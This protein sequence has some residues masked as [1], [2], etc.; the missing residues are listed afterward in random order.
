MIDGSEKQ[1]DRMWEAIPACELHGPS[2]SSLSILSQIST[3]CLYSC[4]KGYKKNSHTN[5]DHSKAKPRSTPV[6]LIPD[7]QAKYDA[8]VELHSR[9]A[10]QFTVVR[11]GGL[12]DEPA[13]GAKAG[14]TQVGKTRWVCRFFIPTSMVHC[15]NIDPSRELV[16]KAL[17]HLAQEPKAAGLTI[18]LMDG[19]DDL[20]QEL[21]KV[22]KDQTDA[23]TG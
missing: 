2:F 3:L 16:A 10:L 14:I 9:K 13:G 21:D 6:E 11:P 5:T 4:P 12:T 1:S 20:V 19:S 17:L 7:M 23:W 18:D 8:E 15:P 22:V